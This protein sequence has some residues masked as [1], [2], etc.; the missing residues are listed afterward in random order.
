[1]GV[2]RRH[3]GRDSVMILGH[4]HVGRRQE[5]IVGLL[6]CSLGSLVQSGLVVHLLLLFD[7]MCGRNSGKWHIGLLARIKIRIRWLLGQLGL[8]V[9]RQRREL[10][11]VSAVDGRGTYGH[12]FRVLMLD[13][14]LFGVDFLML[15][16]VLGPLESFTADLS[17]RPVSQ[18]GSLE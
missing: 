12:G 13:V 5:R 6:S 7:E 17:R 3:S 14:M 18:S 9:M 10:T 2:C 15:L 11:L 1:M 4:T 8:G 16:Q